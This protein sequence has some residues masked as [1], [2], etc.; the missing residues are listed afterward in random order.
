MIEH[1]NSIDK[2]KITVEKLEKLHIKAIETKDKNEQLVKELASSKDADWTKS[3]TY[4][5]K[6]EDLEEINDIKAAEEEKLSKLE[7]EGSFAGHTHDHKA[8]RVFFQKP[9]NEKMVFCEKHRVLGNYLFDEGNIPLAIEQ[10]KIATSYYEYCFPETLE[11]QEN[12]DNVKYACHNNL[13]LCYHRLGQNRLAIES[14]TIVILHMPKNAK[15]YYRR[16]IAY[17]ALDEY[18]NARV[19]LCHAIELCPNDTVVLTELASLRKQEQRALMK[20]REIQS[21]AFHLNV[22]GPSERLESSQ[23]KNEVET[24]SA[25]RPNLYLSILDLNRPLEPIP[26]DLMAPT[27]VLNK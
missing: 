25:V 8:E 4:W 11:D 20:E 19:D 21:Q 17:R 10:Y 1:S 14:A 16:A 6:W 5:S 13:S 24:V 27:N 15:A 2:I 9:E 3:Y 18:Q 22:I 7:S 12:L 26:C 23:S